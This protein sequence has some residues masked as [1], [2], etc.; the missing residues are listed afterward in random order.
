MAEPWKTFYPHVQPH[1]PGC[2]EVTIDYHLQTAAENLCKRAEIW[3]DTLG[4][5]ITVAGVAEYKVSTFGQS[6]LENIPALYLD[7]AKLHRV[8][9]LYHTESPDHPQ[10]K[11]LRFSVYGDETVKFFPTPDK[12]YTFQGTMVLT[13]SAGA[14]GV[15]DFVYE[16]HQQTV[17][18]GALATLMAVPHKEWSDAERA[19]YYHSKFWRCVDDAKG[20]D[21]RRSNLTVAMRPLA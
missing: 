5:E 4:P 1:V 13:P 15:P 7:G 12:E 2:P 14:S 17:T 16:D 20:R 6:R 8:T 21:T 9:D 19:D 3:R 11:P 18:Y 10:G